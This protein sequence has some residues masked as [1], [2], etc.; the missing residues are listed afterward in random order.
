MCNLTFWT[1]NLKPQ[2]T[3]LY[4]LYC[5]IVE[6]DDE[7]NEQS[8]EDSNTSHNTSSHESLTPNKKTDVTFMT[9]AEARNHLRLLWRSDSVVLKALFKSLASSGDV[10]PTDIFFLDVVAVPPSRFRPVSLRFSSHD[11]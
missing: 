2:Q 8:K 4:H 9:V 3:K 11:Y 5:S 1:Y 10:Y 7:D 6:D